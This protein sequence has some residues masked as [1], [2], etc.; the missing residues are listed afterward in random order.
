M[1]NTTLDFEE[2]I[3]VN[4]NIDKVFDQLVFRFS[5]GNTGQGKSPMPMK[6]ELYPG[7]RWYRDTGENEGHLWGFVQ[8]IKSPKLLEF[9]GQL[10]MSYPVSNHIIIRLNETENGTEIVF[11]HTAVGLIEK[12]HREGLG[13]GWKE[14][15]L[16]IKERCE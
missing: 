1:E 6:L 8:S 7:G 15:L 13:K 16:D 10:F 12:D 5:E 3:T 11:R 4:S 9:Y 14:M 2:R